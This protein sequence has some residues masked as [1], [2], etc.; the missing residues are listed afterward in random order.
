MAKIKTTENNSKR[1]IIIENAARLFREK[2]YKAASMRELATA[3]GVEAAS[4]YNHIDN[5]NDLLT[6]ICFNVA[7]NYTSNI[8]K[9]EQENIPV[10]SK[11]E[12]LLRFHVRE[13]I[14]NFSE[15]FVTDTDWRNMEEPHLSEYREMRRNYRKR[16]AE[17]VQEG[18][19]KREIKGVDANSAVMIFI[20]AIAAVDQWHRII[21]KVNSQDLEDNIIT[22]LV[23]GIRN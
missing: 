21:H 11:I 14:I 8:E 9:I 16:F 4:L 15:V 18:I 10:I 7:N 20:N 5:K 22:I 6:A 3:V 12:K 23:N 2:G 13:R 19:D 17:V 1:E